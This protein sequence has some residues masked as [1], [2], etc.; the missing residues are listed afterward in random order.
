MEKRPLLLSSAK[1]A[2]PVAQ[3]RVSVLS[4]I[5]IFLSVL[6]VV[7]GA[8]D[9]LSRIAGLGGFADAAAPAAAVLSR[10]ESRPI[11]APITPERLIIASIGVD[12]RAEHVGLNARGDMA[13][14]SGFTTVAWYKDGARPGEPGNTVI[15]GHL[16]NAIGLSGVFE[17][18]N[19]LKLGDTIVVR[20]EEGEAHYAVREMTVYAAA[21]APEEEIFAT[22]GPS[23]LVLIT[24]DGAWDQG[25]RSYDKRLV[26]VAE[27]I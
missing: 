13:A 1:I 14:P 19:R 23:R 7:I 27:L 11:A 24:C 17:N 4:I 9:I 5:G 20:G 25:R 26:V 21:H 8:L 3:R 15:A 2:V 16:N 12:A 22:S 18:L 10:P 6:L